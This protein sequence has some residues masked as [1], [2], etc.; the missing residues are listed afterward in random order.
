MNWYIIEWFGKYKI[1]CE[2]CHR[3]HIIS[4]KQQVNAYDVMRGHM[5]DSPPYCL[6]CNKEKLSEDVDEDI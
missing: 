1:E 3:Y 6:T 2:E 5:K 4:G